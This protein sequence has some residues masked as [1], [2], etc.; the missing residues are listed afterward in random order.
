MSRR[1]KEQLFRNKGMPNIPKLHVYFEK[2][3]VLS[4][5]DP[6]YL[7][8]NNLGSAKRGVYVWI[9][10][11]CGRGMGRNKTAFSFLQKGKLWF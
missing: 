7:V 2:M 1:D 5:F 4:I 6:T 10:G 11:G 8:L 3:Q 9:G